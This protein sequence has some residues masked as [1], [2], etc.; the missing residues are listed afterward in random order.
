M[1][2]LEMKD[3]HSEHCCAI[4]GCRFSNNERC[5]VVKGSVTQLHKCGESSICPE[6]SA[7]VDYDDETIYDN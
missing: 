7:V 2:V 6:Y 4:H 5:T 1:P 3:I